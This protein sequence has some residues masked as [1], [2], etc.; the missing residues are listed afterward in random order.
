MKNSINTSSAS[1]FPSLIY[2]PCFISRGPWGVE[3]GL[4]EV[5]VQASLPPQQGSSFTVGGWCGAIHYCGAGA[6]ALIDVEKTGGESLLVEYWW[7]SPFWTQRREQAP[8]GPGTLGVW[9][10]S[11]WQAEVEEA[12][13]DNDV[14]V[15][16]YNTNHVSPPGQAFIRSQHIHCHELNFLYC[17]NGGGFF[18]PQSCLEQILRERF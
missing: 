3:E 5:G 6:G 18:S 7:L 17:F 10:H 16:H 11:C 13:W 2:S 9:T 14:P 15:L 12:Q 8:S 1:S 4:R